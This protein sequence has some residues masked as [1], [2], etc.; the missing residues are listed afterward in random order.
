MARGHAGHALDPED[1]GLETGHSTR[2]SNTISDSRRGP[3]H[4][5]HDW[6]IDADMAVTL[7]EFR[8]KQAK[9]DRWRKWPCAMAQLRDALSSQPKR[10]GTP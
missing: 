4:W 10:E 6:M 3:G 8:E 9:A 1:W 5:E 2:S 7:D